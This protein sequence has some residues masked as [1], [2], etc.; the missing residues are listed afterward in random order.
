MYTAVYT[1]V[2][3]MGSSN[4]WAVRTSCVLRHPVSYIV[5][6]YLVSYCLLV[7]QQQ[8]FHHPTLRTSTVILV[9]C[10]EQST[11]SERSEFLIDTSQKKSL[12]VYV[13]VDTYVPGLHPRPPKKKQKA[14]HRLRERHTHNA[15]VIAQQGACNNYGQRYRGCT[16]CL[17]DTESL[18]IRRPFGSIDPNSIRE[19][20][21]HT[22]CRRRRERESLNSPRRDRER[23]AARQ[24]AAATRMRE[25]DEERAERC[26][27]HCLRCQ[28]PYT[29]GAA[30]K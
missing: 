7:R 19:T 21:L 13:Y 20:E 25:I 9:A 14:Q 16:C 17:M 30:A 2:F 22:E 23:D 27:F 24:R 26:V 18:M 4:F 6:A 15:T 8:R 3:G 12:R 1:Y 5:S 10:I 28:Q 11:I 29:L